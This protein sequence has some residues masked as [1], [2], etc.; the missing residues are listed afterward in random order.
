VITNDTVVIK[1]LGWK[2]IIRFDTI[3]GI[4][5]SNVHDPRGNV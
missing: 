5:L 4:E 2:Q 1:Y 3:S